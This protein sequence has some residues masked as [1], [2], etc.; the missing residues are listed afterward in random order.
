MNNDEIERKLRGIIVNISMIEER[1]EMIERSLSKNNKTKAEYDEEMTNECL[2]MIRELTR[3]GHNHY[4]IEGV[5][6]F[7]IAHKKISIKQCNMIKNIYNSIYNDWLD[8]LIITLC[9]NGFSI[10]EIVF[11]LFLYVPDLMNLGET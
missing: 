1:L 6:D 4:Q 10:I 5:I 3:D 11:S 7:Y 9:L 2:S 8:F